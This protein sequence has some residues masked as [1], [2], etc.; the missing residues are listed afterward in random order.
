MTNNRKTYAG[1]WFQDGWNIFVNEMR[2]IFSDSG[3]HLIFFFAGLVY[4]VLY[5]FVYRDGVVNEMPVAVVDLTQGSYSRRIIWELDA[6][7]ELQ[8]ACDCI[9]M[10]E[11]EQLMA[12]QKIHGI[13][14]FP[15]DFDEKV[16]R[17]EQATFSTYA[18]MATFLYY[19]NMMMASNLVMLD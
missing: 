5:N 11:A 16:I 14:Y 1:R 19:K 9:S 12:A 17:M 15:A 13:V 6:T 7:R 2:M 3:V 4:P 10:A 18:D 8:I